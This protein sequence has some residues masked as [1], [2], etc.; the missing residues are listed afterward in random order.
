MSGCVLV[1]LLSVYLPKPSHL[2]GFPHDIRQHSRKTIDH[3]VCDI[4]PSHGFPLFRNHRSMYLWLQKRSKGQDA[5]F[6]MGKH[7][8]LPSIVL[9]SYVLEGPYKDE[10]FYSPFLQVFPLPSSLL[11]CMVK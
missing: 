8:L 4:W 5:S 7:L 2:H 6:N 3:P 10:Q 1:P 11:G 9:L